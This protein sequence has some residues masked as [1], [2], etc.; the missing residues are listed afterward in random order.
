MSRI[1]YAISISDDYDLTAVARYL[2]SGYEA[3][4]LP[5][6]RIVLEGKDDAGWTMD[7]YVLPRLGSGNYWFTEVAGL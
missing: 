1:R 3:T 2:P 5:S 4:I 6:G 7:D